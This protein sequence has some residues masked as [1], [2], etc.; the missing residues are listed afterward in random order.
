[1]RVNETIALAGGI[2]PHTLSACDRHG[3]RFCL[4]PSI[5]RGRIG[6]HCPSS[7]ARCSV[8]AA[9]SHQ[10][11]SRT[12]ISLR[13]LVRLPSVTARGRWRERRRVGRRSKTGPLTLPSA[14]RRPPRV[15]ED[16]RPGA[17]TLSAFIHGVTPWCS[18][19]RDARLHFQT[20]EACSRHP[21]AAATVRRSSGRDTYASTF[22]QHGLL[23][24]SLPV[25]GD[26]LKY[27][28]AGGP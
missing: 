20:R 7:K 12:P 26:N 13:C 9:A 17:K 24:E 8:E 3:R 21:A 5:G 1:M 6:P 11:H 27:G 14:I 23:I 15:C 2:P 19:A 10:A 4:S 25:L 22:P 16:A 18:A 28:R